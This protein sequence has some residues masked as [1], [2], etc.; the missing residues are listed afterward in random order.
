VSVALWTTRGIGQYSPANDA[1]GGHLALF[2]KAYKPNNTV[3]GVVFCHGAGQPETAILGGSTTPNIAAIITAVAALYPTLAVSANF[4]AWGNDA[5]LA[6]MTD[7]IA[8]LQGPLGAKAGKILMI[9]ESMGHAMAASYTRAN[10][11][12][13]SGIVGMLPV[14]DLQDFV[15]NNRG[16]L[17][18]SVNA[19]YGGLYS[20]ATYGSTHN[21]VIYGSSLSAIPIQHWSASDDALVVPSTVAAFASAHGAVET[22]NALTNGHT[23]TTLGLIPISSI[24]TF[25]A[26]HA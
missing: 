25:L 1:T 14:C 10:P 15:T 8:Y 13:V 6:S 23:D 5:S 20:N 16:N 19:A 3:T 21:P 7:A 24:L 22:H 18:T 2:E 17:A 9:G 11:T 4:D 12:K 26:A